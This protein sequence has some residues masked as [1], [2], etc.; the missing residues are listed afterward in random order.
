MPQHDLIKQEILQR[1]INVDQN[2]VATQWAA[3]FVANGP[4][5]TASN[6]AKLL[7]SLIAQ[8]GFMTR[9][10]GSSDLTAPN[11]TL[12]VVDYVSHASRVIIDYK[13]LSE[14]NRAELLSYFSTSLPG[15][16]ARIST[17]AV[18]RSKH[19]IKELKVEIKEL[20]SE[21]NK[22]PLNLAEYCLEPKQQ[23]QPATTS[24]SLRSRKMDLLDSMHFYFSSC[25]S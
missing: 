3:T 25:F 7:I 6:I 2:A 13:G 5:D 1:S 17:H 12:T 24:A 9:S 22:G 20:K 23:P 21:N 15:M 8:G 11:D 18:A 10:D 16:C 4:D 14:P 19:E